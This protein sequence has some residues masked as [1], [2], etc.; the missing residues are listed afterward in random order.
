MRD[1]KG[2]RRV[3]SEYELRVLQ[4][5]ET[6]FTKPPLRSRPNGWLKCAA[7]VQRQARRGLTWNR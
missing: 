2:A 3:L 4:D 6:E 5:L 1:W 7:V